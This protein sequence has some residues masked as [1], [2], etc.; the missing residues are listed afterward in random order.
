MHITPLF[1]LSFITLL[2]TTILSPYI[3][4][5]LPMVAGK[6]VGPILR[7]ISFFFFYILITLVIFNRPKSIKEPHL[8][9]GYA[10]LVIYSLVFT[11]F[12]E[13]SLP[14][15]AI[16]LQC[17]IIYPAIFLFLH[18]YH[19]ATSGTR[20]ELFNH[21]GSS[22]ISHA[23]IF[24][25]SIAIIDVFTKGEMTLLLGYDPNY[26]GEG[27][28]LIT[29]Y[30]ETVR[31]NGG[32]ADALAFGYLM[33]LGFIFFTHK[34]INKKPE[35][36][37]ILGIFLCTLAT[38]LS[39]TR[40]AMIALAVAAMLY[41]LSSRHKILITTAALIPIIF[42]LSFGYS[43][44]L[45]GRFYDTDEGSK[46]SSLMRLEMAKN[47][48]EFLSSNP[49]GQGPGTQGAGNVLS[50]EDRRINTDNFL[51]H[52]LIELGFLGGILFFA[53]IALQ[54]LYIRRHT[55]DKAAAYS[56]IMLFI[57][58]SAL[59]SSLQSATLSL[60]FWTIGF[61]IMTTRKNT[62]GRAIN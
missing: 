60:M 46:S 58:S 55:Q 26:G 16:G 35:L 21:Y 19:Q 37:Y 34:V 17:F 61:I 56:L 51:F 2:L 42:V 40:G 36:I 47:A 52:G 20:I 50:A 33:V 11:P 32:F 6:P 43:E 12:Y 15:I 25:S 39:L 5:W 4:S 31:A 10:L 28:S 41:A 24:M 23:F 14:Q 22:L 8:V 27:F 38:I 3:S 18:A 44:M 45:S 48:M 54:L 13:S 49:M 30:Y 59:S 29:T 62:Q 9:V 57:I 7:F 53:F 1:K